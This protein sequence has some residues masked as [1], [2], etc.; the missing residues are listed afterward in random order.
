MDHPLLESHL[1]PFHVRMF[2]HSLFLTHTANLNIPTDV[3]L[4]PMT[5]ANGTCS[6]VRAGGS[7][8]SLA[9]LAPEVTRHHA[10]PHGISL[11]K[12]IYPFYPPAISAKALRDRTLPHCLCPV[13]ALLRWL[14][15]TKDNSVRVPT[16]F[17][18]APYS[19][20]QWTKS[21]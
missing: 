21:L 19:G 14:S 12:S 2:E 11:Y 13:V 18:P 15:L 6:S 4:F 17:F 8:Q 5:L 10:S 1:S 16:P 20:S 9:L 3:G 7:S